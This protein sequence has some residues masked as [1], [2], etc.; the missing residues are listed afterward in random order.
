[1]KNLKLNFKQWIVIIVPLLL[2]FLPYK[3]KHVTIYLIGDST[4]CVYLPGPSHLTGW[5]MPFADFFD[6]TV[7]VK[8]KAEGGESTRT[9]IEEN[10]WK[11]VA[12]SLKPGDYLLIQFGHNDEV[13]SKERYTT[14][15]DFKA[16]LIRF[17]TEARNKG[18]N[19]VLITPV[20]RRKFDD[21]G[22]IQDVHVVYSALVRN[23]ALEFKVP[24]IDLNKKSQRLLQE[25]GPEK[26]KSLFVA[27]GANPY[28]P[29]D[30]EDITHFNERGARKM[31]EIVLA[32]LKALKIEWANRTVKRNNKKP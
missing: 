20:A 5:G 4:M 26:S 3:K 2:S 17:I 11:P 12:D 14:E 19:P 21:S 8:N 6:P 27:L 29:K 25:F 32:E 1:M 15:K 22:K 24:L 31:A 7:T 10:L 30:Q 23:V 18:A 16:N 28:Y 9:F 13:P